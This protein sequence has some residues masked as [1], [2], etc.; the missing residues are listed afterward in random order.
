MA[1]GNKNL[2]PAISRKHAY[3]SENATCFLPGQTLWTLLCVSIDEIYVT[4][5]QLASE[6]LKL[7]WLFY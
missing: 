4:A 2:A 5:S 7:D 3:L 6:S 1:S